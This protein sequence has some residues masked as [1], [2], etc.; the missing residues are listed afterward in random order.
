MTREIE[1]VRPKDK[2]AWLRAR[3]Q[4]ITASQV[5]ALFDVHDFTTMFEL[6]AVKSGRVQRGTDETDAIRRGRH[7]E[8]VAVNLMRE[9]FPKWNIQHNAAENIYYRDPIARLGATPDVIVEA[10]GKGRGVV[11]VKSVEASV[12]RQK[13][14]DESGQPE[15]PFWIALQ[16]MLEAH[17]TRSTWAAVAPLVVGHGLE[18]PM[19]EIPLDNM[20]GV[21]AA[22]E[23]K[24]AEFW[25]MVAEGREPIP[26]YSRDGATIEAV[27]GSGDPEHE[28]DL[29]TD[30]RVAH[31]IEARREHVAMNAAS[32]KALD[33]IDAEIKAKLG[34]AHVGWVGNGQRIT[35]KPQRRDGFFVEPTTIRALRYPAK[36]E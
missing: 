18:M 35:W 24:A 36:K 14:L 7:L 23:A 6:W 29:S 12:Y 11:Q 5:G 17:L 3:G 4:D 26:D 31:L 32:R 2:A 13:W 30:N 16:A 33:E 20:A 21:I 34:A 8:I 28:I 22:M 9:D 15:P 19:I 1:I 27:Y 25:L 10:P